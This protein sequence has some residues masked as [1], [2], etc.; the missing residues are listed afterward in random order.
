M[1]C[2][3]VVRDASKAGR[4]AE[5]Q[6]PPAAPLMAHAFDRRSLLDELRAKG[7][8]LTAQRRAVVEVIQEASEHLDA[9]ELLE[10]ARAKGAKVDRATVYRTVEMLKRHRLIDELNL[11]QPGEKH[12][13]EARTRG[14]HAHLT[15]LQCGCV[16]ECATPLLDWLKLELATRTGFEL[17]MTRLEVGGLCAQCQKAAMRQE[18]AAAPV[19]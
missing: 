19:R 17:R 4:R 11:M 3:P 12:F 1:F 5:A 15:C 10:R 16:L 8:R 18:T 6:A 9:A 7:I 2:D 13:Y 14:D